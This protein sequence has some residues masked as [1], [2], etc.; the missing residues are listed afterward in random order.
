MTAAE[1]ASLPSKLFTLYL[2]DDYWSIYK[3]ILPEVK[4][5]HQIDRG[6]YDVHYNYRYHVVIP[7][8]DG[9]LVFEQGYQYAANSVD[10][11]FVDEFGI[12]PLLK[13]GDKTHARMAQVIYDR[14][15]GDQVPTYNKKGQ[16]V[17]PLNL[18]KMLGW[19]CERN[20]I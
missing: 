18:D 1:M 12:E 3:N 2:C 13:N 5:S 8:E 10:E 4:V 9:R 20:S 15:I 7:E 19:K 16:F 11:E 17:A 14:T 6:I